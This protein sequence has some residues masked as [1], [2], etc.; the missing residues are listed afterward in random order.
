MP[1]H[2]SGGSSEHAGSFFRPAIQCLDRPGHRERHEREQ[3]VH[4][5]DADTSPIVH[6]VERR[7]AERAQ[8]GVNSATAPQDHHPAK[9]S[10]DHV[11]EQRRDHEKDQ[12]D[13]EEA[14]RARYGIAKR[15]AEQ[16]AG[17]GYDEAE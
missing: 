10:H 16:G 13:F 15:I 3:H 8:S 12:N 11:D 6:E 7:Q 5:C 1:E 9:G 4:H 14:F 2:A 17:D